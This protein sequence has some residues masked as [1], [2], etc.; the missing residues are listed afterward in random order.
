M[1]LT[2][3]EVNF[4]NIQC[5]SLLNTFMKAKDFIKEEKDF[6]KQYWHSKVLRK[7][8]PR[9]DRIESKQAWRLAKDEEDKQF[10]ALVLKHYDDI[11]KKQMIL[12]A[13]EEAQR[14]ADLRRDTQI[15]SINISKK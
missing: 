8:H 15:P 5:V 2:L 13:R 6:S 7:Q 12:D 9:L 14:L 10:H 3:R 11:R 1:L 4:Q